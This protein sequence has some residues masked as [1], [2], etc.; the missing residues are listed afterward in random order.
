MRTLQ[1]I[2]AAACLVCGVSM[3]S[4]DVH[5]FPAPAPKE[6]DFTL[7]LNYDTNLPLY[8][9]VEYSEETRNAVVER[10]DVR[11]IVKAFDADAEGAE[12]RKELYHF[13]FTED[14]VNELNTSLLLSLVPGNY[15]FVVWT[16]YVEAGDCAD[17]YYDT[18]QFEEIALQ[19][20]SHE[21]SNDF[22]DAFR[23]SVVSEVS[24]SIASADVDM[25]RPLARFNFVS[26]DVEDF[27]VKVASVS[28]DEIARNSS[29]VD[30]NEYKAVFYYHGFMPYSYN[31]FTNKPADSKAGVSF[32]S[33]LQRISDNEA[34]L[35]FD[36]VFVNGSESNIV[37]SV[38]IYDHEDRL[39]SSFKPIEVPLVRSKLTTVRA[40]FLTSDAEGGVTVIPDYDGE[41]NY[42]VD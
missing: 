30:L 11:Y 9:V 18:H 38:E 20:E 5:E 19:G 22:R 37:V 6:M 10:Y 7:T 8:K 29:D 33:S 34:E 32:E 1:Y 15:N 12:A 26:I 21:G 14:D 4:C 39:I 42:T 40:R 35:G 36:Y 27:I 24:E 41:Y 13:E 23:G 28:G 17:L 25:E 2:V 31:M 3:S 16:D